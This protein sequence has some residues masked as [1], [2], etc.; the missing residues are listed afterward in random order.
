MK[1]HCEIQ[2]NRSKATVDNH[3]ALK[4]TSRSEKITILGAVGRPWGEPKWGQN[5]RKRRPEIQQKI[6]VFSGWVWDLIFHSSGCKM[7]PKLS[8]NEAK[9]YQKLVAEIEAFFQHFLA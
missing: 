3:Q 4:L 7:E 6:D 5:W 1:I 9:I 2:Q 8:E